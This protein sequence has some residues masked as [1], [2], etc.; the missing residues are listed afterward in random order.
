MRSIAAFL[1]TA[2]ALVL[3]APRCRPR[4]SVVTPVTLTILVGKHGVAGGPKKF[5]GQ[6]EQAR[7]AP[8]QERDR[9]G[10][11]PARLRPREADQEQD[12]GTSASPSPRR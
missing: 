4:T 5:T 12:R 3:A 6:E 11:P 10:R 9:Q 7:R 2:G 1:L 8:G